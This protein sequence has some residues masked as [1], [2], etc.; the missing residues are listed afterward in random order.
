MKVLLTVILATLPCMFAQAQFLH[1]E[2][3]TFDGINLDVPD[4]SG[5]GVAD[6]QTLDTGVDSITDL[7]VRFTLENAPGGDPM[8]YNGDIYAYLSHGTGFAVLLNRVGRVVGLDLG[9]GD[10]GMDVTFD[11]DAP[12]SDIHLYQDDVVPG[13]GLPL[14]GLWK[15]DGRNIDPDF[16]LDTDTRDALFASFNTLNADGNWT[17]YVAD[18]EGG[19]QHRVTSWGLDITG[20]PEPGTA[21]LLAVGALALVHR[22]RGR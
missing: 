17:L 11:E 22:R 18:L 19:A 12:G 10:N 3:F 15:P 1:T 9:Y 8:A 7:S 5:I 2:S 4:G 20:I 16:V 13:A 21:S 6:V 14:G